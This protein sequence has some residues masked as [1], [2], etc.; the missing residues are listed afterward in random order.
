MTAKAGDMN[1]V[2]N[3][4]PAVALA[5]SSEVRNVGSSSPLTKNRTKARFVCP[6]VWRAVAEVMVL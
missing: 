1:P 6:A 5:T 4:C 3:A 2:G